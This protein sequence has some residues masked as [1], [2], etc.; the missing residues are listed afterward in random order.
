MVIMADL[1]DPPQMIPQFL[2]EWEK[3]FKMV[4]AVKDNIRE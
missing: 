3:G 4:L 1:Q 2:A